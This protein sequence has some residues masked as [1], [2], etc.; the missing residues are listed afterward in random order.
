MR[1]LITSL[2][3]VALVAISNTPLA[4]IPQ[5]ISF[6]GILTDDVGTP[7]ANDTRSVEFRIWDAP[8]GISSKWV[9][10][11]T[12]STNAQGSFNV[13]LGS[14]TP[15]TDS[16][17]RQPNRWLSI[18]VETDPEMTPRRQIVSVGYSYRV[19][20][21]DGSIGGSISGNIDLEN[22]NTATGNI[23]KE[24]SLF[25]HNSGN[26]STF[27]GENAG[28]LTMSGDSNTAFGY[29]ALQNN[30]IGFRSTAVGTTALQNNTTGYQNT[31]AGFRAL[32][33]NSVGSDNTAIGVN[34]LR[35]YTGSFNTAIGAHAMY[36]ATTGER[37]TAIGYSALFVNNTGY[38][39][40]ATGYQA[41]LNNSTG[42]GNVAYGSNALAE[43]SSGVNNVAIGSSSLFNNNGSNNTAVGLD[44]LND[45]TDGFYNLA[46]GYNAL[47]ISTSG[48]SNTAI[49][50][51]SL[52]SNTTGSKNS[53]LGYG[54]DVS[55]GNLTNATAI[56]NQAVVNASNKIRLGNSSV[57]VIEGQVSF[58]FP[59]DKNQKE[60]FQPVNG[61]EVLRK[62]S[63]FELTSWN[64]IGHDP[65]KFR[66]YGPMAQDFFDAFGHDGV[67][68]IGSETTINSGDMAGI[69]MIAVQELSKENEMMK[70]L[71]AELQ[72][73]IKDL[74]VI[75][76]NLSKNEIAKK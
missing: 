70:A 32:Q 51:F 18:K 65:E 40:T 17:F 47:S 14:I 33:N 59:S 15:I 38:S 50:T 69:L 24:G 12:V 68:T 11:Q 46:L 22:S 72:K 7:I 23:L 37:N 29:S 41:L 13:L 55:A 63:E 49:G 1:R 42:W 62:I 19:S 30:S 34:T 4:A 66:H 53:A 44:A 58:T 3:L 39:N 25:I 64:Y 54:A 35:S 60:N 45:N 10:T 75:V 2:A 27:M 76:G 16:V 71:N 21:I 5:M 67:G 52:K 56:G 73:R 8:A 43:N 57:T 9:E 28:N 31:A 20:S 48:D 74:E 61:K 36:S 6:Q 26:Q